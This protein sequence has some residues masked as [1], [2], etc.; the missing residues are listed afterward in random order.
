MNKTVPLTIILPSFVSAVPTVFGNEHS[1]YVDVIKQ[2]LMASLTDAGSY[3]VRFSA[4]RSSINYLLLHDKDTAM[5]KHYSD[6]LGPILAVICYFF[7]AL[8]GLFIF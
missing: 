3:E 2:M 5:Q 6:L 7:I 1:Q 4:V 8:V